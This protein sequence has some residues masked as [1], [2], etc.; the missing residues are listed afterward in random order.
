MAISNCLKLKMRIYSLVTESDVQPKV[1]VFIVAVSRKCSKKVFLEIWLN[2]QEKNVPESFLIK[3]FKPIC[4]Q[5]SLSLPSEK[6]GRE[7]VHWDQMD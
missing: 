2:S 3:L 6:V 5:C 7:R 4:S 1:Y